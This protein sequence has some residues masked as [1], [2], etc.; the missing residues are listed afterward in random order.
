MS[1]AFASV[2][3][4]NLLI[5][6][7]GS[8][9]LSALSLERASLAQA[10]SG[11]PLA[12][13]SLLYPTVPHR[14][15]LQNDADNEALRDKFNG[16]GAVEPGSPGYDWFL[17]L[18]IDYKDSQDDKM[19]LLL[20][21]ASTVEILASVLTNF[22]LLPVDK[23]TKYPATTSGCK[24]DG[25]PTTVVIAF[26]YILLCNKRMPQGGTQLMP[27]T[28]TP[29]ISHQRHNN[30]EE[31]KMPTSMWGTLRVCASENIKDCVNA[32]AWD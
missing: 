26:K 14:D 11:L 15:V 27:F 6:T 2:R 30:E 18:G 23:T 17:Q 19:T 7:S 3:Q 25:F 9:S 16:I 31:Y 21:L 5:V 32:L 28:P 4:H 8:D 10:A 20:G 29:S 24:E 13:K 1:S 12:L 22:C